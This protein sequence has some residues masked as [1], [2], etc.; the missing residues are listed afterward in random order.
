MRVC[1]FALVLPLLLLVA[2][3][4]KDE[5]A[6]IPVQGTVYYQGEPVTSGTVVFAPDPSR[7]GSGPLAH[8]VIGP[9]GRFTLHTAESPGAC[10]GWHRV[11]IAGQLT[12]NG[13]PLRLPE[14]YCDPEL[15]RQSHLVKPGSDNVIDLHLD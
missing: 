5:P 3:C 10:P 11:T 7:G 9:D 13:Q 15:A 14:R 6:L 12:R 8:G 1:R 4:S 2:G